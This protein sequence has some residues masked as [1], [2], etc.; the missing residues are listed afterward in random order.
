MEAAAERVKLLTRSILPE[1]PHQLSKSPDWKTRYPLDDTKR[2]CEE[3]QDTRLQYMT[4]VSEADR[5]ILFTRG[6][7]DIRPEPVQPAP[8]DVSIVSRAG[9]EKKKLTLNDYKNKKSGAPPSASASPP[10]SAA[11]AALKKELERS[12]ANT[13]PLDARAPGTKSPQESRKPE[14]NRQSQLDAV[15][16]SRPKAAPSEKPVDMR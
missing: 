3:W 8:K 6:Y 11:S 12:T 2:R 16:S 15:G 10:D 5:G 1:R 14:G 13:T 7:Y 9:G 4:L